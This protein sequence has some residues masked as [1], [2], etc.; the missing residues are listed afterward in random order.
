MTAILIAL[1]AGGVIGAAGWDRLLPGRL[2]ALLSR[3]ALLALLGVMGLRL[4]ADAGVAGALATLGVRAAVFAVATAGGALLA[5][6]AW[7]A[8]PALVRRRR[9]EAFPAALSPGPVANPDDVTAGHGVMAQGLAGGGTARTRGAYHL[10]LL[11]LTAVAV[12]F[13]AGRAVM[14]AGGWSAALERL[15]GPAA[16][17]ILVVLMGLYGREFGREWRAVRAFVLSARWRVLALPLAGGL[18]SLAGGLVA[19]WLTGAPHRE[20]LVV[21]AAFGWYS[22]AGVLV[23]Q[24]WGPAAGTLAFL[25]NVLRE[26]LAVLVVPVLAARLHPDRRW[27]LVLPGGATTMDTTLPVIAASSD[28]GTTALAFVHGLALTALA[29]AL[30]LWLSGL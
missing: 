13:A 11:A 3:L 6:L 25:A 26:L 23:A 16:T 30:M 1:L 29:P 10:S 9:R 28:A 4:G 17:W 12:G 22:L 18:G 5:G 14:A 2:W 27:L 15:L 20:A 19:G 7:Q 24:F 8:V 21:A